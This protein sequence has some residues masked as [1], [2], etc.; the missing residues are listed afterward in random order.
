MRVESISVI[1]LGHLGTC[2]SAVLANA[3]Y[4]VLGVD[5]DQERV[6]TVNRGEA[7]FQE[8][9]LDEYIA[10]AR[11]SLKATTNTVDAVQSTDVSFVVVDTKPVDGKYSLDSVRAAC[12]SIGEGIETKDDF[13]TVA[14]SSTVFPGSTTGDIRTWLEAASGK[15]AGEDF[16]LCHSPE[17]FAVGSIIDDLTRPDFLLIGAF[18]ERAGDAISEVFRDSTEGAPPLVRMSPKE[19]EIAKIT[20]N[21]YITMKISFANTLGEICDGVGGDADAI[22]DALVHDSRIS[23]GYLKPGGIYGGPCFPRDNAVFSTLAAEAGTSAPIA[24]STDAVNEQHNDWIVNEIRE[25]T[26]D[27]GCVA[28]LGLAYKPGTDNP[29]GSQGKAIVRALNGQYDLSGYDPSIGEETNDNLLK[30]ID[31][32]RTAN[33][34]LANADTA[35]ISIPCDEFGNEELYDD[36]TLVD[37]WR[38][39]GDGSLIES[40]SYVPIGQS[41][42]QSTVPP[43]KTEVTSGDTLP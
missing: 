39:F 35:V 4:D 22:A 23:E 2:L 7:P 38:L 6:D 18:D 3:G 10:S 33:D 34:A 24:E 17:F 19:A 15:R 41:T 11:R 16:G 32:C 43:N 27:G 29:E 31:L 42:G 9:K 14:V 21:S 28:V 36:V 37:P 13:H 1:G 5:I 12:Q 25:R 20:L 8:P 40:V 30:R 26:R